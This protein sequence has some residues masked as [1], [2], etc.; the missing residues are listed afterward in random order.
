[1]IVQMSGQLVRYDSGKAIGSDTQPTS[2]ACTVS[3]RQ[4]SALLHRPFPYLGSAH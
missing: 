4:L 1:M 3:Q 2:L